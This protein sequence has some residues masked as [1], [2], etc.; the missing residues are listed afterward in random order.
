VTRFRS[1]PKAPLA[2]AAILATPLFF[3]A[4]MAVSLAVEKPAVLG[5]V[6]RHGRLVAK[7][8]DPAGSTERTIWLLA[9]LFPVA[10]LV[11]GAL[12]MLL[13]RIG[14]VASALAAIA[15]TVAL[16]VPLQTWTAR[17]TARYPVGIDL[18]PRSAASD[19]IYLRGEWEGQAR[20]TARQLGTVTIVI[21]GLA[22]VVLGLL[23]VRRRRGLTGMVIPPP[24]AVAEGQS[25][26]VRGGLGRR[27]FGR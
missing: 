9:V 4:L 20:K 15:A 24:P 10:L 27:W 16:L 22:I 14:V 1:A 6:L 12:A 25:Q 7:L 5:H 23:E 21:A 2:V 11:V 17:H 26:V 3:T 18:V 13:G 8:G 19:D